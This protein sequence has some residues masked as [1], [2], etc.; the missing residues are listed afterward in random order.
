MEYVDG[1]TLQEI[2]LRGPLP[3]DELIRYA[4][5]M[6]EGLAKAHQMGIVHR[7]LKPENIVIR[8]DGFVK[9]LDF[10]L[11][12]LTPEVMRADSEMR[13]MDRVV[14]REGVIVGTVSYMSPEQAAGRPVDFRSDQFALGSI[15]YEMATGK[16]PFDR[17]TTAQSLAAI[18]EDEP[19]LVTL[20]NPNVAATTARV[21][22]RCLSRDPR[23]R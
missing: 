11:A 5:Q 1:K 12:K 13:T 20:V 15:L 6:A 17:G 16:R 21:I 2:L 18:I 3:H 7:D 19:E 8:R 9:I 23:E 4:T 14:T 22:D 10:G